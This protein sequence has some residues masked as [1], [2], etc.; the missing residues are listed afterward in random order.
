M[1]VTSPHYKPEI[2]GL[3]AIAVL[4][5]ILFHIWPSSLSG[6]FLGVDVFF[7]ISG[8]LITSNIARKQEQGTFTLK[9][10][11]TSRIKRL[12]PAVI[13]VAFVSG[14]IA[15]FIYLPKDVIE[16][17]E[18]AFF[19]MAQAAN[20][21]FAYF[22]DTGYFADSSTEK[23]LLHLWSLAVEEQFYLF[24]PITLL[25][26]LQI[27]S[28]YLRFIA[29]LG[30]IILSFWH[31]E[32][33]LKDH[34]EYAYYMITTRAA[35]LLG[36]A[37]L[38]LGIKDKLL[39]RLTN[40]WL[41]NIL[42]LIGLIGIGYCFYTMNE[43]DGFPGLSAVPITA[44][45]S[46][47]IY[48][49]LF[50]RHIFFPLLTNRI[51]L[52]IGAIS[53]SLYLWHWP[54]LAFARYSFVDINIINGILLFILMFVLSVASYYLVENKFKKN[55]FN[56]GQAFTQLSLA[57]AFLTASALIL[58]LKLNGFLPVRDWKTASAEIVKIEKVKPAFK[59][60]DVLQKRQLKQ[61]DF[62]VGKNLLNKDGIQDPKIL[63]WGDSNAAQYVSM[64]KTFAK[65]GN[66]SFQNV[67]SSACP[68]IFGNLDGIIGDRV[69][70]Y[71][72]HNL[73][74]IESQLKG[75]DIIIMGGSWQVYSNRSSKTIDKLEKT[76]T[77]LTNDGKQVMLLLQMQRMKGLNR[78][79]GARAVINPIINCETRFNVGAPTI[80]PVNAELKKIAENNP[81][82]T[83]INPN[84]WICPDNVCNAYYGN[85]ILYY[86][87]T[88][89][90]YEA[91]I[92]IAKRVIKKDGFPKQLK[93]LDR[94]DQAK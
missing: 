31:G 19:S 29:V 37:I 79:C 89:I 14:I 60:P 30:L 61:N 67:S 72:P 56:F 27:K 81:A 22:V 55:S 63:L 5:V 74:M 26:L 59:Y 16:F 85:E 1:S 44:F 39:P 50:G 57:P 80:N 84:I 68:P 7:V 35:E 93:L 42:A 23:P 15:S 65:A 88:H 3:R 83:L 48:S 40:I 38:A 52:F 62:K 11:Y 13:C 54:V 49:G 91:G 6:G 9:S 10:F 69:K 21:Y 33:A 8:F 70:K 90:G 51:A 28:K 75:F 86:D 58:T 77:K 92:N 4:G 53:Y 34:P 87:Q 32:Q 82:V 2:D 73:S 20:V 17:W 46:L 24:W 66:F 64:F 12:F 41:R 76:I 36:G 94:R 45:S 47:L 25:L 43:A 18:S 78:T 71:C